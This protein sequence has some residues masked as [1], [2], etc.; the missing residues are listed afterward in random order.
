TDV[1]NFSSDADAQKKIADKVMELKKASDIGTQFQKALEASSNKS[2]NNILDSLKDKDTSKYI[3]ELTDTII[4]ALEISPKWLAISGE[5]NLSAEK[6]NE[7]FGS[8]QQAFEKLKEQLTAGS[9]AQKVNQ[10]VE[11]YTSEKKDREDQEQQLTKSLEAAQNV[12]KEGSVAQKVEQLVKLYTSEKKA[13]DDQE[14]KLTESLEAAKNVQKDVSVYDQIKN[15]VS[16]YNDRG[17]QVHVYGALLFEY[18]YLPKPSEETNL[19]SWKD[20]I[21]KR[22]DIRISLKWFILGEV[23]ACQ[24]AVAILKDKGDAELDNCLKALDMD[25]TITKYLADMIQRNDKSD[26]DFYNYGVSNNGLHKLFRAAALLQ[27]YYPD[28]EDLKVLNTHLQAITWR[29]RAVFAELP[30]LEIQFVEP[31]LLEAAP[32]GCKV[33][34]STDS[35]LRKLS[36]VKKR[37]SEHGQPNDNFIVDIKTYGKKDNKYGRTEMTVIVYDPSWWT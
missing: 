12:S 13:R 29:L 21:I 23:I 34:H 31:K 20:E 35:S 32:E 30:E 25:E 16:I 6:L 2:S 4:V 28:N 17:E 15:L 27:T 1:E 37:V 36:A 8:V 19:S 24:A 7:F 5:E 9:A 3:T 14:Q 22:Q 26:A 11:L 33:D 10:L 18:F